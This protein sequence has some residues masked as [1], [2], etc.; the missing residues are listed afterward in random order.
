MG[1]HEQELLNCLR[2]IVNGGD[3]KEGHDLLQIIEAEEEAIRNEQDPY[4]NDTHSE[5]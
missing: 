5:Y 2:K 3:I 1:C 4:G